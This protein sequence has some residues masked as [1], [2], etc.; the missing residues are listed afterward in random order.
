MPIRLGDLA[1][2]D[3]SLHVRCRQCGRSVMMPGKLLA[4]K[5]GAE[6][7]LMELLGRLRCERDQMVPD[8]RIVLDSTAANREAL[9]R[10]ISIHEPRW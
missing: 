9:R 3:A 2:D 1:D 5:H 8:A 10:R 7:P 6:M 4:K